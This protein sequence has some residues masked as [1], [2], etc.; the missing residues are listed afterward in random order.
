MR[1]IFFP[2]SKPTFVDGKR[3]I[4]EI[5]KLAKRVAEKHKNIEN[6][7]LFGSYANGNAGFRSDADILIILSQDDRPIK[8]RLGDFIMEFSDAPVPI[9]VL[10]YTQS[11]IEMAMEENN[12]FLKRALSGI[13]LI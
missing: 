12:R 1:K 13:K 8:E 6:I 3:I 10:V 4:S 9:D 2:S 11:E 7:Y 5:K